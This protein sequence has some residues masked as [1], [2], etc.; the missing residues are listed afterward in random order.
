MTPV[1]L[2]TDRLILRAWRESDRAPFAELNAD[3]VSMRYFPKTLTR[4]ESDAFIDSTMERMNARGWGAFAMERKS[5]GAFIGMT[6]INAPRFEACF[7]PC[8]EAGWRI[9]R[10]HEGKGYVTEAA[11][12]CLAFAFETLVEPQV[13]AFTVPMNAPSRAVMQRI[14]MHYVEGGDF[15]HP[16]VADGHELKRHVL[17]RITRD[18][19]RSSVHGR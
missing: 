18:E 9:L 12:R 11:L 1:T 13:Y 6:G 17:Y 14:G 7:T 15:D 3:P 8:V 2:E 5:D 10:A 4:A 19:W 16:N